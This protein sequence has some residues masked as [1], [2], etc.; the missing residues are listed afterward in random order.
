MAADAEGNIWIA[1]YGTDSVYVFLGGD[2]HHAVP[3]QEYPGSQPFGM[4]IAADGTAWV[5]NS[6]G[7][8]GEDPRS[9]A[10]FALVNGALQRQFLRFLEKRSKVWRSIH[11]ETAGLLPKATA[12]SMDSGLM[13]LG[14]DN[15]RAAA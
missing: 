3:F 8:N 6:G 7:I 10:K 9:V 2:P 14:S 15:S 13:A 4:V 12:R 1:S 5:T 11:R